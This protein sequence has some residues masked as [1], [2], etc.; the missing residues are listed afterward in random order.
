MGKR[1]GQHFL[2]DGP[3]IARIAREA[4][5]GSPHS[6]VE[7]GPGHGELTDTLLAGGAENIIAVERDSLLADM[8]RSKYRAHRRVEII[9]GDIRKVL[10]TLPASHYP[11][12]TAHYTI[13][14]NIPY[15]LTGFLLRSLGDMAAR[16]E[17]KATRV[18]LLVQKEVAMRATANAPHMNLLA[19]VIQ[20]WARPRVAFSVPRGSFSP[21]PKVDS[22]LLTLEPEM[23]MPHGELAHYLVTVKKLFRQ[24]RKTLANNLREGFS[25]TRARTETVMEALGVEKNARAAELT[26]LHIK[27]L[28]KMMYN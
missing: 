12:L 1:L 27:T 19:A 25:L 21:P 10:P 24:P 13:V 2:K 20:G 17:L 4:L 14:G 28:A 23:K 9:E 11:L 15:Y 3:A 16:D 7:I 6:I 18:V 22:A 5:D 8:L 26:L